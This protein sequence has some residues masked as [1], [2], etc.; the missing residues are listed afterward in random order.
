MEKK[1]S[2]FVVKRLHFSN[3]MDFI[4][5]W[6]L[7]LKNFFDCGWTW[8]ELLKIRA[9][10]QNMTVRSSLVYTKVKSFVHSSRSY[11]EFHSGKVWSTNHTQLKLQEATHLPCPGWDCGI[12]KRQKFAT[13]FFKTEFML[14]LD[15]NKKWMPVISDLAI[16]KLS[17]FVKRHSQNWYHWI[18]QMAKMESL[19]N[20]YPMLIQV[21]ATTCVVYSMCV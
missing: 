14:F 3:F 9:G 21:C 17:I 11:L 8:T 19:L 1:C 2:I 10:S 12:I 16:H 7:H 5:T 4:W 18:A 15:T 13:G 20:T 6:T